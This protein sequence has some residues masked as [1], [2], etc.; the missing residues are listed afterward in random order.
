MTRTTPQQEAERPSARP[1]SVRE[2]SSAER[3]AARAAQLLDSGTIDID[4]TDKFYLDK[5]I[6]P[7]GWSYE[8]KTKTVMGAE[9]PAYQVELTRMGWEAVPAKRHPEMMPMDY[10][11]G[12]IERDGLVLMERPEIITR[13]VQDRDKKAA[14]D[15]VRAGEER[16]NDAPAGQFERANKDNPL[17]KIKKTMEPIDIPDD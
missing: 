11:G 2:P 13:R 3:A 14:R 5:S 7:E 15:Q 1:D 9:N 10:K 12:T 6:I 4:T 8:W 16:L 17:A